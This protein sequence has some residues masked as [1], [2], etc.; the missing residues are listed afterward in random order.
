MGFLGKINPEMT[1]KQLICIFVIS[2][3]WTNA[4]DVG[5]LQIT[6]GSRNVSIKFP[7]KCKLKV[8]TTDNL[9]LETYGITK[10]KNSLIHN[11]LD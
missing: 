6:I 2:I 1:L 3:V 7:G 11:R 5:N 8:G 9:P 4:I 10:L